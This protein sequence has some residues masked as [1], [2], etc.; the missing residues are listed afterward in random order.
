MWNFISSYFKG[1]LNNKHPIYNEKQ[2]LVFQKIY[3]LPTKTGYYFG[4]MLFIMFIGAVNYNNNMT[5]FLSFF[6]GAIAANTMWYTH[7]NIAKLVIH[8]PNVEN[9]FAGSMAKFEYLIENKD[10]KKRYVVTLSVEYENKKYFSYV[11]LE[12]NSSQYALLAIPVS[13]RGQLA[14]EH[15]QIH[16]SFPLGLFKAWSYIR[17]SQFCW[18]YPK[19]VEDYPIQFSSISTEDGKNT[20]KN[21]G[22]GTEDFSHLRNYQAGDSPKHIAWK[23]LARTNSLLTKQYSELGSQDIWLD[24]FSLKESPEKRLSILCRWVIDAQT[25]QLQYGLRLPAIEIAPDNNLEH[26]QRC[27]I[28]LASFK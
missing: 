8:P 3:I 18:V 17:F 14:L 25:Q 7:R 28:A 20:V 22:Q 5:F 11:D 6:L 16:S 27:L 23:A 13:K 21:I 24:W 12:E 26:Y 1:W 15:I 10:N 19:P 2:Q 4:L 9:I